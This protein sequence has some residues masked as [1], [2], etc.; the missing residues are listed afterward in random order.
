MINQR[1]NQPEAF[2]N[3]QMHVHGLDCSA[4][5]AFAQVVDARNDQHALFVAE[6]GDIDPV[7]VVIRFDIVETAFSRGVQIDWQDTDEGFVG[8]VIG[9]DLLHIGRRNLAGELLP[10]ADRQ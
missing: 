2:I 3:A 8:I 1:S 6:H 10:G 4:R 7:G 5:G 9:D